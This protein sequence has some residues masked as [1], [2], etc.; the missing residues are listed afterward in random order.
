MT[1]AWQRLVGTLILLGT[2]GLTTCQAFV[3]SSPI[4]G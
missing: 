4:A 3:A 1:A 2:M